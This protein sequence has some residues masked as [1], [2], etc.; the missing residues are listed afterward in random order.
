MKS[1]ASVSL[2][3]SVDPE[4]NFTVLGETLAA[5]AASR[6]G[7]LG[8]TGSVTWQPQSGGDHDSRKWFVCSECKIPHLW[9]QTTFIWMK[10]DTLPDFPADKMKCSGC[11]LDKGQDDV[12]MGSFAPWAAICL[13]LRLDDDHVSCDRL[14]DMVRQ[15]HSVPQTPASFKEAKEK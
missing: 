7:S 8:S 3:N 14:V 12:M 13:P 9:N 2:S 10:P 15:S 6:M 1:N 5:E 11:G 4:D